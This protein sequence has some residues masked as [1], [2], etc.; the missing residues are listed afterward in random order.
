MSEI[1][2]CNGYVKVENLIDERTIQ[3]I[4]QY[5]ENKI[6]RG[7]WVQKSEEELKEGDFSKLY[8]YADPLLEV[9]LKEYLPLVEEQTGLE[10]QPTYSYARVYQEGE[11]LKAHTDRPSCQ[12]SATV[13]VAHIGGNWPIWMQYENN[14]PAKFLL[15][16]GDAV[17]YKGCEVMHWRRKL[18]EGQL[19][20]QFMLHYVD[21]NGPHAGYKFDK[22]EVLGLDT[23]ARRS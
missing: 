13:N 9:I 16:P 3:T 12:I 20:V 10:L 14:D 2:N 7:E 8:Y 6:K 21:K 18:P 5:L 15:T 17:I 19:Y 1:F 11:K 23:S 4:S 22:R